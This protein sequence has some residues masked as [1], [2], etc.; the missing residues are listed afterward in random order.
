LKLIVT[1]AAY[2]Q[3]SRVSEASA[4]LDPYNR[5]LSRGPRTRLSAEAL[6]DQALCVSGLLSPKMFGPPVHP[7]QPVNGLAAAF[8][9]STD[10]QTSQGD[11]AHRRALYTRWR[12]NL[13]Y[14][15]MIAFDVPERAVCSM[16][17]TPT[18]TPIQALVTL[19]DPVF[20]EAAQSLA[21]RI[22]SEGGSTT[23]SKAAFGLRNVLLRPPTG[24]ETEKLAVLYESARSSLAAGP[25]NAVSLATKP[26]GPL[27]AGLDPLEAAS[28]T[29]VA[30]VLLNLDESL[31]RP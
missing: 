7:F 31:A 14:P 8:G 18:N 25:T 30:N 27:P 10:W 11:D 17:R 19:N 20:V 5:L 16:R 22:A 2:R 21:R 13:P 28:W 26:I 4:R 3:S 15:S 9:A 6:R 23:R 1:S 29:V 12:R 24:A